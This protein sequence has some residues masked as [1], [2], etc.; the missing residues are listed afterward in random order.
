MEIELARGVAIF[1]ARAGRE[2]RLFL[3]EYPIEKSTQ[4]LSYESIG[5]LHLLA[6]LVLYALSL[7]FLIVTLFR[8][9][10]KYHYLSLFMPKTNP[11]ISFPRK[12]FLWPLLFLVV[13]LILG[14]LVDSDLFRVIG[15]IFVGIG[16][17]WATILFIIFPIK[18]LSTLPEK[19][20]YTKRQ[21][22]ILTIMSLFWQIWAV[23]LGMSFGDS[24]STI[25]NWL[26][27]IGVVGGLGL[28]LLFKQKES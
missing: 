7:V 16:G 27:G 17:L 22:I 15:I 24:S 26:M 28:S 20:T 5:L 1:R 3:E 6:K 13:G 19:T 8:K 4:S 2:A 21:M 23:G 25:A 18:Y 9:S 14:F 12:P 10:F 11:K